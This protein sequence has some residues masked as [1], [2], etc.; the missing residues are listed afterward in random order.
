M[1]DQ[2]KLV[3]QILA[4]RS[5]RVF[6]EYQIMIGFGL[7]TMQAIQMIKTESGLKQLARTQNIF[8]CFERK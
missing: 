7:W 3:T 4:L 2:V 5:H 6:A 8:F 1:T